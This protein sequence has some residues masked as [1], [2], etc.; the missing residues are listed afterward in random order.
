MYC[1]AIRG[2]PSLGRRLCTENFVKFGYMV[3]EI[4]ERTD[5][6]TGKLYRHADCNTL[7]LYHGQSIK[8]VGNI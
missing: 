1:I 2:G 4:G 3:Y 5:K 8:K 6:Q 7:H